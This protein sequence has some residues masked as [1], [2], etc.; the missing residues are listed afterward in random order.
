MSSKLGIKIDQLR[1]TISQSRYLLLFQTPLSSGSDVSLILGSVGK[2]KKSSAKGTLILHVFRVTCRVLTESSISLRVGNG[3]STTNPFPAEA[4]AD[5]PFVCADPV[6][7]QIDPNVSLS[8]LYLLLFFLLF[9][10]ISSVFS[11]FLL[12]P[13]PPPPPPLLFFSASSLFSS[14]AFSPLTFLN[15]DSASLYFPPIPLSWI[16]FY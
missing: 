8:Y 11:F 2:K 13:P 9:S 6:G 15:L 4:N 12:P 5:L 16:T 3:P 14:S 10:E 7:L 1:V